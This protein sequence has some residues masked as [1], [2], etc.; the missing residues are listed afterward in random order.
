VCVC[1]VYKVKFSINSFSKQ[2]KQN[3]FCSHSHY[4]WREVW[5]HYTLT[6]VNIVFKMAIESEGQM[7]QTTQW[8]IIGIVVAIDLKRNQTQLSPYLCVENMRQYI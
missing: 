6:L 4:F 5:S 7:P 2:N 8:D 1:V 3:V